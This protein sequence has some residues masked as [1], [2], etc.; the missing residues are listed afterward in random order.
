M[1]T[2]TAITPTRSTNFAQWYQQVI[3]GTEKLFFMVTPREL[4]S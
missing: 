3:R 1:R 2:K 4:K